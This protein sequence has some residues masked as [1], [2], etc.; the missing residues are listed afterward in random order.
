MGKDWDFH[1]LGVY[2]LLEKPCSDNEVD[3]DKIT[4][5]DRNSYNDDNVNDRGC[6][7]RENQGKRRFLSRSGKIRKV[8]EL[9]LW[10]GKI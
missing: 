7:I 2:I 10:S 9:F 4:N 1:T 3:D 8:R 5:K 6:T